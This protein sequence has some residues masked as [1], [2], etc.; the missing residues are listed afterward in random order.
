MSDEFDMNSLLQQAQQMQA[1]LVAAQEQAATTEVVGDAGGGRVV[2]TM[3][4]GGDVLGVK[5]APEVVD[6]DD[7][8]MLQDLVHG[9]IADAL[10]K[11]AQAQ[12]DA[13]G[14]LGGL[15]GGDLGGLGGLL[16]G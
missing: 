7:I 4:A 1:Q 11:G 8:D 16:G 5:I 3:T 14:P 12:Q 9:A 10:Y 15:T 13:M 2:I 6:P